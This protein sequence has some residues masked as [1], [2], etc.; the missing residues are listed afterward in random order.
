MLQPEPGQV[1][2]FPIVDAIQEFQVVTSAPSAE[3]GRFHGG[4]INLTTRSGTNDPHGTLFWFLRNEALNARNLFATGGGRP[5]F[6]RNQIN[7]SLN[8]VYINFSCG[9]SRAA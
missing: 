4:V 7:S 5:L 9:S 1:A 3:F 6:R 8:C 2:F